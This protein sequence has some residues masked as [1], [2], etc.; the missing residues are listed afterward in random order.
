MAS[1]VNPSSFSYSFIESTTQHFSPMISGAPGITALASVTL[2]DTLSGTHGPP[3]EITTTNSFSTTSN[4]STTEIVPATW[5]NNITSPIPT[6]TSVHVTTVDASSD[7]LPGTASSS[8][9]FPSQTNSA[10]TSSG[11]TQSNDG[12]STHGGN[13]KH[14]MALLVAVAVVVNFGFAA[15]T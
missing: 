6:V 4:A 15:M 11:T 12:E 2:N 3:P 1:S 13:V 8:A 9:T 7:S 5:S 10:A 14:K